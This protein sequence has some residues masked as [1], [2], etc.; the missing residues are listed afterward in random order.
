MLSGRSAGDVTTTRVE[1]GYLSGIERFEDAAPVQL[2]VS[3]EG[4][5]V[6][7]QIPGT[8]SVKIPSSSIIDATCTDAS[9]MIETSS[10]RPKSRW[11]AFWPSALRKKETSYA[12]A[13]DYIL[14]IQYK[15]GDETHHAMFHREDSAG[16]T[17]VEGLARIVMAL[18]RQSG[19]EGGGDTGTG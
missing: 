19:G 2:I 14:T 10:I 3:A 7:E 16:M 9:S 5:E 6:S 18:A 17:V 15:E 4:V 13:Y 11:W 8:R 12:K 1:I